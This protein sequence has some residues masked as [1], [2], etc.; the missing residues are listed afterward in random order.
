[1]RNGSPRILYVTRV[2]P[3]VNGAYLRSLNILRALQQ[4]GHVEVVALEG[5]GLKFQMRIPISS[6]T[7][8]IFG[9]SLVP[10]MDCVTNSDGQLIRGS[11]IQTGGP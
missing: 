7:S 2:W 8:H 1:M 5:V 10:I 11:N 4:I 9:L 6:L 3:S